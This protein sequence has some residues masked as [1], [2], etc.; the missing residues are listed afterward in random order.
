MRQ[1]PV[2]IYMN[3]EELKTLSTAINDEKHGYDDVGSPQS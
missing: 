1:I 3:E 2:F